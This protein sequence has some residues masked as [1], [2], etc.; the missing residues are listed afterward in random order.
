MA[1]KNALLFFIDALRYDLVDDEKTRQSLMPNLNRLLKNGFYTR[2]VANAG[3]TQYF[4]PSN[5]T[6]TYPLDYDG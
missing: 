4:L 3:D 6:Q 1:K 5:L 2:V